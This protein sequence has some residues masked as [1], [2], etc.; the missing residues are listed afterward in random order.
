MDECI[1]NMEPEKIKD[2]L[3][4]VGITPSGIARD[5][6]LSTS[7]VFRVVNG[8]TASDRVRRH[9]ALCIN[10]PVEEIWPATYLV[11]DDPTKKGR[12]LSR[13]LFDQVAA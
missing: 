6:E 8:L 12:P 9:I 3:R 4:A 11:K 2:A 13:G 10:V 1:K 5:L 7:Q